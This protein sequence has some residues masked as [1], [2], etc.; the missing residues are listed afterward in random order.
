MRTESSHRLLD[1]KQA[2]EYLGCSHW[3][4]RDMVAS[5]ELGFVRVGRLLKVDRGDLDKFIEAAK[6]QYAS[7]NR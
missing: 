5:G 6:F 7:A 1:A 2:G 4:I 3:K